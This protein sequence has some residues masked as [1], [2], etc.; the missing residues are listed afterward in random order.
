MSVAEEIRGLTLCVCDSTLEPFIEYM[1]T[2]DITPCSWLEIP[3]N[4]RLDNVG[5]KM[6]TVCKNNSIA[7]L[8]V[9][10]FDIECTSG[11]GSFPNP[12]KATDSIIMIASIFKRFTEDKPYLK[13]VVI[14]GN[15]APSTDDTVYEIVDN[16]K[17]LINKWIQVISKNKPDIITGYN[18]VS[19]DM[20]Y[21]WERMLFLNKS[22]KNNT[23]IKHSLVRHPTECSNYESKK[24][25]QA[26]LAIMISIIS[27]YLV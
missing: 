15:V 25:D 7:P 24:L 27:I 5:N 22:D 3:D 11:D 21:I 6:I 8:V 17:D 2:N 20:K 14:L 16:E 19:F 23:L 1:N 9:A 18:T 12:D 26:L 10:S 4:C 13:H